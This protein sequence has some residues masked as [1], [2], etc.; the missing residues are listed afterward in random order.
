MLIFLYKE[1]KRNKTNKNKPVIMNNKNVAHNTMKINTDQHSVRQIATNRKRNDSI[2][3]ICTHKY[4]SISSEPST[5][6]KCKWLLLLKDFTKS[7]YIYMYILH[8]SCK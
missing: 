8:V 5:T 4:V 6:N 2:S 3:S 1:K 7:A